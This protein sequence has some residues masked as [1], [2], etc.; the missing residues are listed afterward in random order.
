MAKRPGLAYMGRHS[1]TLCDKCDK[2]LPDYIGE[3]IKR[4]VRLK[5]ALAKVFE[6]G[7]DFCDKCLI[8][9]LNEVVN[10]TAEINKE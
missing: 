2:G 10:K 4:N 8:E 7:Q 6:P 9:V 5:M 3:R 1:Y